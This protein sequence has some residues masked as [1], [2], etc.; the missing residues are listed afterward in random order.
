MT[1]SSNDKDRAIF[2]KQLRQN[3]VDLFTSKLKTI[4]SELDDSS[5][6]RKRD[7]K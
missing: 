4:T 2:I 6:T 1:D 7:K 5:N 3:N